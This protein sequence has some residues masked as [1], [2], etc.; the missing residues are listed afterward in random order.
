MAAI[1]GLHLVRFGT[2]ADQAYLLNEFSAT[3]DQLVINANTIAH[4]PAAMATFLAVRA[5]KPFFIDPQTHAFQH[6]VDHLLSTSKKS[7]GS[8]KRSWKNLIERYGNPIA[9]IIQDDVARSILPEDF[10][11]VEECRAFVQRVAAFQLNTLS[12]QFKQGPD[13]DYVSYLAEE[14]GTPNLVE[15]SI[16]VAPYFFLTAQFFE[17]WLRVNI[18]CLEFGREVLHEANATA[19]LAAQIVISQDVLMV[20]ELRERLVE[21]YGAANARPEVILLWIDRFS[22]HERSAA[23]L[24]AYVQLVSDLAETGA[25][26]VNLYGGYFSVAAA[27]FGP[28]QNK[29]AGVCHG[30]EYGETKP[31]VP[32]SGGIPVAKFYVPAVHGRL[33]PRV[34]TRVIRAL[35]GFDSAEAFYRSICDCV[36]CQKIIQRDP[37]REFGEYTE[38]KISTF[39][40]SGKRV[41]M[42]FPTA[43]ASDLCT[44]HYMWCKYREYTEAMD[45]P[46]T[47]ESFQREFDTLKRSVG[48]DY[49]GHCKT[50]PAVLSPA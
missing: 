30:L 13:A 16:V 35:G 46:A 17:E 18:R 12:D 3:F 50:W 48:L 26:V 19:G 8:V 25:T 33:A 36:T 1:A 37:P 15:P 21:A 27:R 28:L 4:M 44:R 23:E 32:I 11:D 42:D 5:Q 22:E 47:C 41:S 24:R 2:A 45:L 7:A 29:L 43:K 10:D 9:R 20:S 31:T 39:W 49:V 40:R 38:T 6:E 14:A 34:A